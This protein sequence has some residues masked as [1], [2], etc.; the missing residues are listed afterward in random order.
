ML[1]TSL[2]VPP[3]PNP[4][5]VSPLTREFLAG[6]AI[7]VAVILARSFSLAYPLELS[8][9]ESELLV[10]IGRYEQDLLPWRSVDGSTIGP[11]NPWFLLLVKQTGWPM[12]YGGIHCLAALLQALIAVVGYFTLRLFLPFGAALVAGAVGT[13]ALGC[14]A[15]INFMYFATE[16]VP[17][18][19]LALSVF[20]LIWAQQG[21]A[22]A[23]AM[24]L[25]GAFCA[26]LA[27]WAK[28]Q[29]APL[30]A[31]LG[32]F[33]LWIAWTRITRDQ[34]PARRLATVGLVGLV[35]AAPTIGIVTAV[36]LG[37]VFHD[38]WASYLVANVGYAGDFTLSAAGRRFLEMLW[39]SQLNGLMAG[40]VALTV[41]GFFLRRRSG[42]DDSTRWLRLFT[43]LYLGTAVFCCIR[44]PH[45]FG[46]YHIFLIAPL[47]VTVGMV[48]HRVLPDLPRLSGLRSVVAILCVAVPTTLLS[49][50]H[51][52]EGA[53][54]RDHLRGRQRDADRSFVTIVSQAILRAAPDAS[55]MVVWGWM[56]SLY[57]KTG[58]HCAT[59]HT[60]GHFLIVPGPSR[61]HLRQQFLDDVVANEPQVIVDAVASDSFNW[62]WPVE[63]SGIESFPAFAAYVR[64]N[65]TQVL[66]AL[67]D[68]E[69]VP[70]RV[71]V[72]KP[73]V[74]AVP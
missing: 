39:H 32:G 49:L 38:F 9:D 23:W 53:G 20:A 15:S 51:Y 36:S 6:C 22:A 54:L 72:R 56:P 18:L 44:P 74:A 61:D 11:V 29:A 52:R 16:L 35:F 65:Y 67:G 41:C 50:Q 58:L 19:A 46:H 31:L 40:L 34:P 71:F 30:G 57:V 60:I 14:S 70:L 12:G 13:L 1:V 28:L 59:R 10:Q 43:W 2:R 26:G 17:A 25:F 27:P 7:F 45:G 47:F 4:P 24:L 55:Q 33:A 3:P 48:L 68:K 8:A 37:G 63:S 69:G 21:R 66:S 42:S 5:K 64:A 73:A 62:S